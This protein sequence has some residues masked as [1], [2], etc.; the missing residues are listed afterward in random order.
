MGTP[1]PPPKREDQRR[2]TNKPDG[3]AV[4]QA[5]AGP[6]FDIPEPGAKWHSIAK[7]L[8]EAM[9]EAGQSAFYEK[10]DWLVAWATCEAMSREFN[11]PGPISASTFTSWVKAWEKLLLTEADRRK[12]RIELVRE[13]LDK[14]EGEG[15]IT[16]VEEYKQ[17]FGVIQGGG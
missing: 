2:R 6:A 8:Y 12:A 10:T 9:Q 15:V 11:R 13:G 3:V 16:S 1:G 17:R 4:V 5:P 14:T 7:E